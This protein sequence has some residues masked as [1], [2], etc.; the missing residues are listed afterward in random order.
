MS[1]FVDGVRELGEVPFQPLGTGR[2]STGV[3]QN[4]VSWF[5]GRIH[6]VDI[7]PTALATRLQ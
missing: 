5:K 4:R 3:R 7:A 2:T 1:H 6:R